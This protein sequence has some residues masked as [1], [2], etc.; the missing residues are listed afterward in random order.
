LGGVFFKAENPEK[1]YEWYEKQLGIKQ[2]VPG[3]GVPFRWKEDGDPE[4]CTVRSIF[5]PDT[6]YFHPST[7]PFMLNFRVED[8]DGLLERLRGEGVWIAPNREDY[9]YGRF[10]WIMDPE[11]NRI[12]LWEPPRSS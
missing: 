8:L 6:K 2:D 1:L 4:G 10:A 3:Q 12:E 9:D 7:K 11:E 5:K